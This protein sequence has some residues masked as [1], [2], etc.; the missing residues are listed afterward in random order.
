MDKMGLAALE[1]VLALYR[2]PELLAQRL[3]TLRLSRTQRT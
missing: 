3:P 1:A 2:E